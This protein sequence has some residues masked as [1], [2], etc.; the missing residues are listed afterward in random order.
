MQRQCNVVQKGAT[1]IKCGQASHFS[2][3]PAISPHF[4]SFSPFFRGLLDTGILRIWI[5]PRPA[6]AA[7]A[8]A[9]TGGSGGRL[10]CFLHLRTPPP[11]KEN[12]SWHHTPVAARAATSTRTDRWEVS[13]IDGRQRDSN[14]RHQDWRRVLRRSDSGRHRWNIPHPGERQVVPPLTD[15]LSHVHETST[16]A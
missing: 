7:R 16:C 14:R 9:G 5:L 11:Q 2:L 8:T 10:V 4:P 3:F 15:S 1:T 12:A 6:T 13:P